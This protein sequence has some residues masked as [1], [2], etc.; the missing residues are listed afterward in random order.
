M[1]KLWKHLHLLRYLSSSDNGVIRRRIIESATSE[2]LTVFSEISLNILRGI[3]DLSD[4]ELSVLERNKTVLRKLADKNVDINEKRRHLLKRSICLK[5]LLSVFFEYLPSLQKN[6]RKHQET[7]RDSPDS[8]PEADP[9]QGKV[10]YELADSSGTSD[11]GDDDDDEFD[12][13]DADRPQR[14]YE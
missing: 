3:F 5:H 11:S 4:Q 6:G 14:I 2:Q 7:S 10:G 13:N 8:I 1:E 9:K 12:G